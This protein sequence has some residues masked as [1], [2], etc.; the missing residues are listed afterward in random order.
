M[1]ILDWLFGR[2]RDSSCEDRLPLSREM[3]STGL[4]EAVMSSKRLTDAVEYFRQPDRLPYRSPYADDVIRVPEFLPRKPGVYAWYF[5]VVPRTVLEGFPTR[6]LITIQGW[7]LLYVG[8]AGSHADNLR[9]RI[10]SLHLGQSKRGNAEGSTLRRSLGC[11]LLQNELAI[12]LQRQK[13]GGKTVW[14]GEEGEAQ[15]TAWM[16]QNGRIAWLEA[17]DPREIESKVFETYGHCLPF[18]ISHDNRERNPFSERL[19]D[20]RR[21][22]G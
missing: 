21:L 13:P 4:T 1:R 7:T 12:S 11:C 8:I 3:A 16:I 9:V 18:N 14:F 20:L 10:R 22:P 19:R 15:L 17:T 2:N 6:N 5:R